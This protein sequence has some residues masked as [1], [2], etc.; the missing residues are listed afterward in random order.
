MM[1][2]LLA[3][4]EGVVHRPIHPVAEAELVGEPD[5]EA[6]GLK[7]VAVRSDAVHHLRA[8]VA[9]EEVLDVLPHLKAL[10]VILL[11]FHREF[12]PRR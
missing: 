2:S 8:V 11:A 7:N 3:G 12:A 10:A 6:V 5:G 1:H 9:V 4:L